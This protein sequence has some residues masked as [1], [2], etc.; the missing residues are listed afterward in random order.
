MA[1]ESED[2]TALSQDQSDSSR[3]PRGWQSIN[4]KE[5]AGL[6]AAF[7]RELD[8][9]HALANTRWWLVARHQVEDSL[10][11][12]APNLQPRFY[13]L[14][15][16]W[17]RSRPKEP[18]ALDQLSALDG[19]LDPPGD[20]I[21]ELSLWCRDRDEKG[22]VFVEHLLDGRQRLYVLDWPDLQAPPQD[23]QALKARGWRPITAALYPKADHKG[24]LLATGQRV[25][26]WLRPVVDDFM[27]F[28]AI[29]TP[30]E[31]IS[32]K[33]LMPDDG[34]ILEF[35]DQAALERALPP[36]FYCRFISPQA[37][38]FGQSALAATQ[39]ES[40]AQPPKRDGWWGHLW[41]TLGRFFRH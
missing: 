20:T 27:L 7:A 3:L 18:Y 36:G 32:L 15:L 30:G 33:K 40:P 41:S 25:E 39:P 12:E 9:K 28:R 37:V 22:L 21:D 34:L 31:A 14:H 26:Y 16:A 1:A 4:D 24:Q 19:I 10:V 8:P 38:G 11:A 17:D 13:L 6:T 2:K 35:E 5:R 23:C 29:Q